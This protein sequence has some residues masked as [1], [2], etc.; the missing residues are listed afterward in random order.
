MGH[1]IRRDIVVCTEV[2]EAIVVSGRRL[3]DSGDASCSPVVRITRAFEGMVSGHSGGATRAD[4]QRAEST[5]VHS[6]R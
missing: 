1:V 2:A 5:G 6:D 4:G 3:G